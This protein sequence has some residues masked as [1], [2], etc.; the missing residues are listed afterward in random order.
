MTSCCRG[1]SSALRFREDWL[2]HADWIELP[3]VGHFPSFEIPLEGS[4]LIL[5]FS[6]TLS[7]CRSLLG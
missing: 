6:S 3:D 2:P 7:K 4:Q 1:A 5:G